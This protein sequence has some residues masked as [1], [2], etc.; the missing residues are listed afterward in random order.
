[1]MSA[2]HPKADI[3]SS[4]DHVRFTPESGHQSFLLRAV[5][6]DT[7]HSI[8]LIPFGS[9]LH[10]LSQSHFTYSSKPGEDVALIIDPDFF[11]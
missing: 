4:F 10:E 8:V 11:G 2:I 9:V 7:A 6:L 1:M 3:R 5:T